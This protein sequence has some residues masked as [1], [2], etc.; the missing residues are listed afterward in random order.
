MASSPR[1]KDMRELAR[2]AQRGEADARAELLGALYDVVRKHI[3]FVV[4]PSA[5]AD[6]AVQETRIALHRGLRSF[7]GDASP[8]TWAVAIASRI[9]RKVR[10]K[11]RRHAASDLAEDLAVF[12]ADMT[13]A[14]ELVL[15]RSA[16]ETLS[17]KKRELD[18]LAAPERALELADEMLVAWPSHALL[19]EARSLRCRALRQLGRGGAC[20]PPTAARPAA[21]RWGARS[22][23]LDP[24][25][26]SE[27]S[28]G[29]VL[30]D[31]RIH[32][33]RAH[34][35]AKLPPE[36]AIVVGGEPLGLRLGEKRAHLTTG[37]CDAIGPT[38]ST[39]AS[40]AVGRRATRR[41]DTS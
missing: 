39:H 26:R 8:R 19:G 13:D 20:S 33:Q 6:D 2:R 38:A 5:I 30:V 24:A 17:A 7:R 1:S 40:A 11:E 23:A 14:A 31:V 34:G 27:A 18:A 35:Q 12:D 16:L 32:A 15:L 22:G 25:R 37:H 36:S 29:A 21:R 4:G 28:P 10:R 9:A 41:A 3:H